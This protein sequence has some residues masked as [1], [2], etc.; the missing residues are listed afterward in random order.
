MLTYNN[1]KIKFNVRQGSVKALA[2]L[3]IGVRGGRTCGRERFRR[4]RSH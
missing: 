1:D 2:G 4:Y 3:R